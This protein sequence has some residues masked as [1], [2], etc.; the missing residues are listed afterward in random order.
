MASLQL[1]TCLLV[2]GPS[3]TRHIVSAATGRLQMRLRRH[4]HGYGGLG[5]A[6]DDGYLADKPLYSTHFV[7]PGRA[8]PRT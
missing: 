7:S 5:R 6:S 4:D 2:A 1:C 3:D 8:T